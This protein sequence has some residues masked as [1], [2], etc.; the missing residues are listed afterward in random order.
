MPSKRSFRI[1]TYGLLVFCCV[2]LAHFSHAAKLPVPSDLT[3]HEW[4]TFTSIAGDDGQAVSWLPLTGP[5][6]LPG[7]V[8]RNTYASKIGLSGTVRMETPVL[9][10]HA[11]R[12]MTLSVKVS[13]AKGV[14]TEWYPHASH[15][16][17]SANPN[18]V[19]TA[20]LPPLSIDQRDTKDG[21]IAWDAVEVDPSFK[22]DLP[23]ENGDSRYYAA[24]GTSATPLRVKRP[25]GDQQEKF[26]FYR[27]VSDFPV[28]ISAHLTPDGAT[29]LVRN[30]GQE[31]IPNIILF[32]RRGNRL[33]YNFCHTVR[34]EVVLDSPE[35]TGTIDSL[36]KNMED[37]LVAQ[38]LYADEARA[39]VQTWSDSWF[40]EGSRLIY[41]VPIQ[42]VNAILPL[43]IYP[44]PAQTVRVFV[45]RIELITPASENAIV[46]AFESND[47]ATLRK[48]GRFLSPILA[49]M[50]QRTSD[51]DRRQKLSTY[52]NSAPR[53][54]AQN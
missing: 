42:F 9:Y 38:G 3:V 19:Y 32:E 12:A 11:P 23:R 46:T 45:G 10:F 13:F 1:S 17:P 31:A 14:I 7:F 5:P 21:S 44:V 47:G 25:N 15:V 34:D 20:N 24:R 36:D 35:L 54:V 53:Y 33:G 48:Y 4:G 51:K 52:L 8:E 37:I 22:A 50:M 26:L 6:D 30:P 16:G 27:G 40:E 29:L 39:M 2:L 18:N 41:I 43:S 28:P 49:E